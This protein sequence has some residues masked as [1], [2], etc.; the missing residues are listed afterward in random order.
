MRELY[1]DMNMNITGE[2]LEANPN[3]I[4]VFGDNTIR[5][6]K[7]GAASLRDYTN[8]Y[9]FITKR[10]PSYD[11]NDYYGIEEYKQIYLDELIKLKEFITKNDDKIFLISPIGSGLA[12]RFG[13]WDN[14]IKPNLKND[15]KEFNNI[16]WLY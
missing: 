5:K 3:C 1:K 12:N 11:D 6:G 9:G 2:F 13:I 8:T 16:L 14:I 4:F 10:F 7:G 15:L